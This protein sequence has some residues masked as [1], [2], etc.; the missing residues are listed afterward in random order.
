MAIL[1]LEDKACSKFGGAE[2]SMFKYIEH[3]NE[4]KQ[5][6]V[7]VY[8][9]E[10][11]WLEIENISNFKDVLKLDLRPVTSQGINCLKTL[12][13]LRSFCKRHNVNKI[14]TH[15]V[16]C[17]PLL[18]LLKITLKIE[19]IVYFKWVVNHEDI[20]LLNNWGL[21]AI[22][23][24]FGNSQFVVDYWSRKD[25]N[26]N[27]TLLPNGISIPDNFKPNNS[28]K[29][30]KFLL[31]VGRIYEGKGLLELIKMLPSAPNLKLIVCGF[32]NAQDEHENLEYHKKISETISELRLN[33][34]VDFKGFVKQPLEYMTSETL[35]VIP[36]IWPESSS[37]VLYEAM[38]T[39]TSVIASEFGGMG[40][41]LGSA[42]EM[43]LVN[44][45]KDEL[46][47][48]INDFERM[49]TL[50][51]KEISEYLFDR[52]NNNYNIAFTQSEL[53]DNLL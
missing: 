53:D 12:N 28:F 44:P 30:I 33:N 4:I 7:L 39:K 16:H 14:F 18:R 6:V 2:K 21:K 22:D 23:R 29:D 31:F 11:T 1:I 19:V 34:Q 45:R 17:F 24:A 50:K 52:F 20:G 51:R 3:L 25:V 13:A 10:G 49:S 40:D 37:R 46:L 35:V 43:C 5:E 15:T 41:V 42:S 38:M 32:F 47:S 27:I 8:D 26:C 48:K 36:S 9:R